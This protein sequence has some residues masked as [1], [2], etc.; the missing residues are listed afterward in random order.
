[1]GELEEPQ[2]VGH[3]FFKKPC[4]RTPCRH[5]IDT[6][7]NKHEDLKHLLRTTRVSFALAHFWGWRGG[8]C[9]QN[10]VHKTGNHQATWEVTPFSDWE[11][12]FPW[13]WAHSLDFLP[14]GPVPE[15]QWLLTP[16]PGRCPLGWP[17]VCQCSHPWCLGICWSKLKLPG[18]AQRVC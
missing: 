3:L 13:R 17:A 4:V 1:M 10:E 15:P 9:T 16:C 6:T 18:R 7:A 14:S 2:A 12:W 11:L 8:G 5:Q